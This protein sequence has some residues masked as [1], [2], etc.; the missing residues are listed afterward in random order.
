M[1]MRNCKTALLHVAYIAGA[2]W[3]GAHELA[4]HNIT[5]SD[6]YKG[7]TE[8]PV[9]YPL[10]PPVVPSV[11][12]LQPSTST[13]TIFDAST[14]TT[15]EYITVTRDNDPTPLPYIH[16]GLSSRN[17]YANSSFVLGAIPYVVPFFKSSYGQAFT[18]ILSSISSHPV[19]KA[20]CQATAS[21]ISFLLYLWSILP[22]GK[23]GLNTLALALFLYALQ[24]A[25][26]W[27]P[28]ARWFSRL[29]R[30]R[31]NKS[32]PSRGSGPSPPPSPPSSGRPG[33]DDNDSPPGSPKPPKD[34][35]SAGTQ[36]TPINTRSAE[37]QTTGLITEGE[38]NCLNEV[39]LLR[40]ELATKSRNIATLEQTI[41]KRNDRISSLSKSL[42]D[43]SALNRELDARIRV[44]DRERDA[45]D[46]N[47]RREIK[48]LRAQI[49]TSASE[50]QAKID[51]IE[52]LEEA[53]GAQIRE[54]KAD[55]DNAISKQ[56][57]SSSG[58]AENA[59]NAEERQR[60]ER[61]IRDL[62]EEIRSL[63]ET[64]QRQQA[65]HA[66]E[67][68]RAV[69][70]EC[71]QAWTD[72]EMTKRRLEQSHE[73]VAGLRKQ[74][75][76]AQGLFAPPTPQVVALRDEVAA[77][78][79]AL[80]QKEAE[81]A[82]VGEQKKL[83]VEAQNEHER[84][85]ADCNSKVEALESENTGLTQQN[86]AL[87]EQER[88]AKQAEEKANKEIE[89]LQAQVDTL[90]RSLLLAGAGDEAAAGLQQEISDVTKR[91]EALQTRVDEM[92][93]DL[94]Q[95]RASRDTAVRQQQEDAA[96]AQ[97]LRK[98]EEQLNGRISSLE[99]DLLQARNAHAADVR[100]Q[101]QEKNTAS[102]ETQKLTTALQN[103]DNNTSRV[104]HEF[105]QAQNNN[106][107]LSEELQ[108]LKAAHKESTD[109]NQRYK[110]AGDDLHNAHE[111]LKQAHANLITVK[112]A[113]EEQA[114]MNLLNA[115]QENATLHNEIG[116]LNGK[117]QEMNYENMEAQDVVT[118]LEAQVKELQ[119]HVTAR[120]QEIERQ[121]RFNTTLTN[122]NNDLNHELQL[123]NDL[124]AALAADAN[125][126]PSGTQTYAPDQHMVGTNP[127]TN[128]P[129][130][131][132]PH[133]GASPFASPL[134]SPG[135]R[136]FAPLRKRSPKRDTTG[137]SKDPA[138]EILDW[139]NNIS[140]DNTTSTSTRPI[141]TDFTNGALGNAPVLQPNHN[142][143]T[144]AA[145]HT[146]NPAAPG[147]P[148]DPALGGTAPLVTP[149]AASTPLTRDQERIIHNAREL[150]ARQQRQHEERKEESKR[151]YSEILGV[152]SDRQHQE[153]L[154]EGRR[155]HEEA[156]QNQREYDLANF[157]DDDSPTGAADGPPDTRMDAEP[158]DNT[159]ADT[160]MSSYPH[161]VPNSEQEI[162][163]L[164]TL[165]G[166]DN[167]AGIHDELYRRHNYQPP[168][169]FD[170]FDGPLFRNELVVGHPDEIFFLRNMVGNADGRYDALYRGNNYRMPDDWDEFD[171][172]V[173]Y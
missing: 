147:T 64:L 162:A 2:I 45:D 100:Q 150:E 139:C 110:E 12:P 138:Q 1:A 82:A 113:E 88:A 47:H 151:V 23:Q 50:L 63:R 137:E 106:R 21:L 52:R 114:K 166:N 128:P 163:F 136:K 143:A 85:L 126:T 109:L 157:E 131:P 81:D 98:S 115:A 172:P 148:L 118:D 161:G 31:N 97:R 10:N 55:H 29:F 146:Q 54:L 96:T 48:E 11:E 80:S 145:G 92:Q 70:R 51:E 72:L 91:E 99:Q 27:D 35:S 160:E 165:P 83:S 125:Q 14:V 68:D 53:H 111:A 123:N 107:L 76:K 89:A 120:D 112:Q 58:P 77:L 95:A 13:P 4:L 133:T 93:Q 34:T 25:Y 73:T 116:N 60:S 168:D 171:N 108:G 46:Q 30:R 8:S 122:N 142:F 37:A 173:W 44:F 17:P 61:Q 84:A 40:G 156:L 158:T 117:I 32:P 28:L 67:V 87:L 38:R 101:Q 69:T 103:A 22:G 7:P 130:F 152:T 79:E 19:T 59:N 49:N 121:R 169:G 20:I 104:Q 43:G 132:P 24:F 159:S 56:S 141:V 140:A 119:N 164:R 170:E 36:T 90:E 74:L 75:K 154:E 144:G 155:R 167:S 86:E 124:A 134:P 15:T 6:V 153:M 5:D 127:L 149:G 71:S 129:T 26:F 9:A 66:L 41:S 62:Q 105:L 42:R 16:R 3:I 135:G 102:A 78:K 33:G 65:E 18:H 94:S 39:A 57:E